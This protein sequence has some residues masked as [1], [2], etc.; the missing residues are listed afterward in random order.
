MGAHLKTALNTTWSETRNYSD[1]MYVHIGL[2]FDYKTVAA[3]GGCGQTCARP[4]RMCP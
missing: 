1:E 2:L 4:K 3:A